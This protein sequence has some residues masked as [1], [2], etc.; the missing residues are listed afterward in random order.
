MQEDISP[1]GYIYWLFQIYVKSSSDPLLRFEPYFPAEFIHQELKEIKSQTGSR[2]FLFYNI[3]RTE[4]FRE[5]FVLCIF[6]Y[7]VTALFDECPKLSL[8]ARRI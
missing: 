4:Q 1:T 7:P 8:A 3:V 2:W 6:G 5:N